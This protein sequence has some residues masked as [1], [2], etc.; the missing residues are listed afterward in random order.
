MK[1]SEIPFHE[2]AKRRLRDIVD[3][4]HIPHALL[5]EGQSGSGKFSLARAYAQ[6]VH[7]TN[8]T[9]DGDSCGQC[10]SCIQHEKFNHIDTYYIFPILK[11]NGKSAF[12][13]DYLPEF[14]ELLSESPFM[15]FD[16]WL[17]KLGNVNGQPSI[18]ADEVG[19]LVERMNRTAR[20]SKYKIVVMWLPERLQE[21]AAN[22]L[23]KLLEEPHSDTLFILTSD[24]PSEILPTIY[25]RVQRIAVRRYTDREA[26]G[27]LVSGGIDE[28][29][30]MGAAALAE[31]DVNTAMRSLGRGDDSGAFLELFI[32]LMRWA[33]QRKVAELRAWSNDIAGLGREGSA[34][35][36][37]YCARM[38][39]ENFIMN[40]G[41]ADLNSMS[42]AEADFSSKF[43]PF[44]NAANV[45]DIF[46]ALTDARNDT[47]MNGNGK[48]ISFDLAVK[49]IL[50]IKRATDS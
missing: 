5:L 16:L 37:E 40:L 21:A 3:S 22:K 50:L 25:S 13:E 38:I 33:W 19:A 12:C 27:I 17:S 18:Y 28:S 8:R 45:L 49:M 11:K 20:Q 46:Q 41:V 32:N 36:Y 31:G 2:D 4:G 9:P 47:L 42:K 34:R 1:F 43:S 10:P 39:R 14:R 6:Y 7:C 15:D 48:I 24:N 26:A 30:A 44:I 23:L 35:F 29:A